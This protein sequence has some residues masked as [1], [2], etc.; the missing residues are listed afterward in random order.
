VVK[1]SERKADYLPPFGAEVKNGWSFTYTLPIYLH[2]VQILHNAAI[3]VHQTPQNDLSTSIRGS[4]EWIDLSE[5]FPSVGFARLQMFTV[6][7]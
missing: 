4:E 1:G 7:S 5:K 2:I 3:Q 6:A